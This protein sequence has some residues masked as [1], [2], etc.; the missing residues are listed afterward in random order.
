M[1]S[2]S[3]VLTGDQLAELAALAQARHKT[4]EEA[5]AEIVQAALPAKPATRRY[6]VLDIIGLVETNGEPDSRLHDQIVAKEA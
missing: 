4:P 2:I 3:I 5:L 6:S 1:T